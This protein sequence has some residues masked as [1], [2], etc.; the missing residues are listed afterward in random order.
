MYLATTLNQSELNHSFMELSSL[1]NLDNWKALSTMT[2]EL[3]AKHSIIPH[4]QHCR[5]SDGVLLISFTSIFQHDL[6]ALRLIDLDQ[7]VNP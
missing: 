7:C 3:L 5:Y 2:L 4:L 6:T 1:E